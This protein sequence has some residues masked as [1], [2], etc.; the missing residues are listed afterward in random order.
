MSKVIRTLSLEGYVTRESRDGYATA[1]MGK[2][3]T[4]DGKGDVI[5]DY[6]D[7]DLYPNDTRVNVATGVITQPASLKG[8]GLLRHSGNLYAQSDQ[9]TVRTVE[10]FNAFLRSL[11]A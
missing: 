8:H 6:V 1:L 3:D 10:Q 2:E 9:Y 11:K 5:E 4:P 7:A